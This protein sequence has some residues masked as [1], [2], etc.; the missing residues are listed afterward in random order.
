MHNKQI[1]LYFFNKSCPIESRVCSFNN[2]PKC[3]IK[4]FLESDKFSHNAGATKPATNTL[5]RK[6]HISVNCYFQYISGIYHTLVLYRSILMFR[7]GI[8]WMY[9]VD[10][11]YTSIPLGEKMLEKKIYVTVRA[12]RK[13]VPPLI[14]KKQTVKNALVAVHSEQL[15]SISWMDRK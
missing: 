3:M 5:A 15:L 11:Y 10:N 13:G 1:T 4:I 2:S 7:A 9:H 12:N 6:S 14:Y 8:Q